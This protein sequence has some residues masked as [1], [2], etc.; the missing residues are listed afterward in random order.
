L[1]AGVGNTKE[2]GMNTATA[3]RQPPQAGLLSLA[4][5]MGVLLGASYSSAQAAETCEPWMAKVVAVEGIV[6]ARR[7]GETVWQPVSA[8][9]IYCP[10]DMIR[11]QE[12][13]R[14]ALALRNEINLRLDQHTTISLPALEQERTSFLDLLIG[15]AYFFSRV[16]RSLRVMTPFVNAAVE[17]TEFFVK[18]EPD[19]RRAGIGGESGRQPHARERPIGHR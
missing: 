14:A 3:A 19:L 11:V 10:G 15:A 13:G 18:V 6:Q 17:G 7:A 8:G 12:H 1:G 16:P 4:I 2:M 9:E 5:M